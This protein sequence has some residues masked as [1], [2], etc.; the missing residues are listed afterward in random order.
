[1]TGPV[2]TAK[3]AETVVRLS[4][5]FVLGPIDLEARAGETVVMV[6]ASGSG[7]STVLRLFAGLVVADRGRVEVFGEPLVPARHDTVRRR[8]GYVTQEGGLFPHLDVRANAT[9]RARALGRGAEEIEERFTSLAR[10]ARVDPSLFARLP[11]ELSGGQR[12][13]VALVR[14]LMDEPGLVLLDE[15]LGALDPVVRSELRRD[16]R[17]LLR[18]SGA[19]VVMVT[20]DLDE[21]VALGDEIVVVHEGRIDARGS[22]ADLRAA[23]RGSFTA[24]LLDACLGEVAT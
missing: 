19:A 11:F 3:L 15:P 20:H 1:V 8:I 18:R 14:A 12:Q 2:V 6:G 23:E 9:L 21:A 7:K 4:R 13:R 24:R 5:D 16:L 10:L 17:D 22:L